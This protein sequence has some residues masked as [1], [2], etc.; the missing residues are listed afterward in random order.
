MIRPTSCTAFAMVALLASTALPA[1]AQDSK[2]IKITTDVGFV[3]AAGNTAVTTFNVGQELLASVGPWGVKQTFG[4]IYGRTEGQVSA[5]LWRAGLRG[6]RII[7]GRIGA[8]VLG[9]FDRNTFAGISRRYEEGAGLVM[10]LVNSDTDRL[11]FE[12]GGGLTQ[13]T[14]TLATDLS[15]ASARAA[16]T[17]RRSFAEASYAQIMA[18]LLPNL[19]D[20]EDLRLN[21][22]AELVAPIS[23]SLAMKLAYM[24]RVDNLPEPGFVKS[25]RV[26]TAGLQFTF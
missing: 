16:S 14:S 5:S 23:R 20:S 7:G 12:A 13:Q 9:G 21:S 4:V 8:Y 24:L 11:E 18:E 22:S 25:D 26:F 6:D 19:E 2:P 1:H 15:F 3:N 17:Y 10:T